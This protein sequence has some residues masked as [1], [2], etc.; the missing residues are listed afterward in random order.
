MKKSRRLISGVFS[1]LIAVSTI[2]P[3]VFAEDAAPEDNEQAAEETVLK[4]AMK[5]VAVEAEDWGPS[6]TKAVIEFEEE[7]AAGG[8]K[9][10]DLSVKDIKNGTEGVMRVTD[11][12]TSD[13]NGNK[14]DGASKFVTLDFF[15]AHR[16][17]SPF[18]G[19][20]ANLFG[21]PWAEQYALE[22]TLNE[23]AVITTAAGTEISAVEIAS[24]INLRDRNNVIVPILDAWQKDEYQSSGDPGYRLPYAYYTPSEDDHKNALVIWFHGGGEG[25]LDPDNILL[26]AEVTA[27]ASDEFQNKFDGA[28]ILT[29]ECFPQNNG[30]M[31]GQGYVEPAYELITK[32][33]DEHPDIDTNR[34]I[35]GGC[36]MGGGM[37]LNMIFRHRDLFAA[38]FLICPDESQVNGD[39]NEKPEMSWEDYE[40]I[41]DLP[42]WFIQ[43]KND[44]TKI[45]EYCAYY[46]RDKAI[47]AGNTEVHS[48][49]YEDVHDI[50][51][52]YFMD[53]DGNFTYENTG[54]PW[55]YAGHW[56]WIYF[57]NNYVKDDET[58]INM[59]DWMA[60][61][62]QVK[63][64][65]DDVQD[66]ERYFYEPVYWAYN[67][68]PYQI[69]KGT[70]D[71]AF[72]PDA[73]VTRG[74]MVTFLWRLAGQPSASAPCTFSD[75]DQSR[76]FADAIA[77]ASENNITT[78][79]AGTDKFGPED[80]CTREQIVTFLH[81]Y[82][83]KPAPAEAA[84]FTD[85][86]ENAY[87]LDALSWASENGITKGLNDGTGRFGVGHSCT[88]AMCV[89]FLYRYAK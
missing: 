60:E 59:W 39:Y 68:K 83:G 53:E 7:I 63:F 8:V 58:G 3:A 81:R 87:Y 22:T 5:K 41:K 1:A 57:F 12:Y 27:L 71:T 65:F 17:G 28:Y 62:T 11:A 36:S 34:V 21:T 40:A 4:G 85:T 75:V 43:A 73:D 84:D 38:A 66:E 26:G 19:M 61:Q 46:F 48:T 45:I 9:A 24:G 35:V 54:K 6:V 13:E 52:Q 56:S 67:H 23:G 42:L 77:W 72:S 18:G 89:T 29:P 30:F 37:T 86:K 79:Y 51:G 88:R 15:V 49:I 14:T 55:E 10:S 78:G 47:E 69:T 16:F 76:Y 25:G 74:Q 32:F 82:A 50:T 2:N 64:L 80:K 33:I 20:F 70:S 44:T 31:W